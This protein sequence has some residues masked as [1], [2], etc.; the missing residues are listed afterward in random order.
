MARAVAPLTLP[1]L[2]GPWAGD[3]RKEALRG[4]DPLESAANS[5]CRGGGEGQGGPGDGRAQAAR[6]QGKEESLACCSCRG[7]LGT[8]GA[9][10]AGWLLLWL[11][12][13]RSGVPVAQGV[14][15][16]DDALPQA[17]LPQ[18]VGRF[19][20]SLPLSVGR[21]ESG[22]SRAFTFP[23]LSPGDAV[24]V[25]WRTS[26][27]E[28]AKTISLVLQ[29]SRQIQKKYGSHDTHVGQKVQLKIGMGAVPGADPWHSPVSQGASHRQGMWGSLLGLVPNESISCERSR[30]QL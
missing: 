15:L 26:P 16:Q 5:V 4:G 17:H 14:V 30:G 10:A 20:L 12:Q 21:G 29:C 2:V 9:T 27:Q 23:S 19:L 28:L 6:L 3:G 8:G 13:E 18:H 1:P 24:L 7:A 22:L 11:A 25:L